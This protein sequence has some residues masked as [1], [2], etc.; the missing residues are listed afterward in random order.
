MTPLTRLKCIPAGLIIFCFL[1]S[2]IAFAQKAAP[3]AKTAYTISSIS[4]E[5]T[6]D[7]MQLIVQGHT[8]PTYTMYELFDPL[9]IVLDIADAKIVDSASIPANLPL[10][11]V[12][13]IKSIALTDQD[14]AIARLEIY[15]ADDPAYTIERKGNNIVVS[16]A[17]TMPLPAQLTQAVA[18]TEAK[19]PPATTAIPSPHPASLLQDIE[20]DTTNPAETLVFIKTDGPVKDY[21][22]AHLVKGGGRPA[23]MYIDIANVALPGK[24]LQHTVGTAL[25]KIRAAQH[26][27]AVRIVFDSGLN[28]LFPYEV[29]NR[30]D[31]LLIKIAESSTIAAPVVANLPPRE[32]PK[33]PAPPVA[34]VNKEMQEQPMVATAP[35]NPAP[36][37]AAPAVHTEIQE[38]ALVTTAP[39]AELIIP[40]IASLKPKAKTTP[41]KAVVPAPP[42]KKSPEKTQ[43]DSLGFAGYETQ[44][45][46]VDFFKIDLHN[47]FRLFG[48]ISGKNIVVDEGVNGT[49][50]LALTDIPWDF[51]LDII[52]NLKDLQK[53]ERF[54][55]IVISPKS[56][57][58]NWPKGATDALAVKGGVTVESISVKQRIETPTGVVE[59][60]NLIQL[61]TA[62][63][64]SNQYEKALSLYEAAFK[65]W[66][67]NAML[68]SRIASLCLTRLGMNAKAV[69]YAKATLTLEPR[70]AEA[71]LQAAIGSANMKNTEA[72]KAYFDL[73]ISG[74]APASEALI[75]Y[76]S[77]AEE[78]QSYNGAL[79]LL[80]RHETL[81]GD[82]LDT[83]VAKARILDKLG[84]SAQ[85][86]EAYNTVLLSGYTIPED[87]QQ[88]IRGRIAAAN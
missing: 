8:P 68:T 51:A 25:A 59:A 35:K 14:P 38:T 46:T 15:L 1:L 41:K 77:F 29:E 85:A 44:K 84:L 2:G 30:P 10:G 49:L 11:P 80:T 63:E 67:E 83:L 87:L 76:A 78:Y 17:K 73:A 16:F 20:I 58:F 88:F 86:V 24:M 62:A 3:Q 7:G 74:D 48:E 42:A 50:T 33:T 6:A 57:Q 27:S 13:S 64:K 79:A 5:Q 23:R 60:K 75:S 52:L 56:K 28:E 54:N 81:F 45:I 72:A 82:T 43:A 19:Q 26:K 47:V 40:K 22:K 34:T 36:P 39:P 55:T 37:V 61:A 21:K 69:H 71:A 70:N 53:E 18:E 12:Q 4:L 9:R 31:G 66:P 32:E 65:N